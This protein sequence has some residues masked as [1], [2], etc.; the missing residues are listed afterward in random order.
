MFL[1][2][3][4][5][6]HSEKKNIILILKKKGDLEDPGKPYVIKKEGIL[7]QIN[8]KWEHNR[9]LCD[10][11]LYQVLFKETQ[12]GKWKV[13]TPDSPCR[14]Q[15]LVVDGLKAD[16]SYVFKVRVTEEN[17]GYDG[18]FSPESNIIKT[19]ETPA[20]RIRKKS[21]KVATGPPDVYMLPI[22]ENT[23]ARNETAQTRKFTLGK[24]IENRKI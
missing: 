18:P 14:T 8:L 23:A 24:C 19:D 12:D 6:K 16:T 11:E 4:C 1:K 7:D 9:D 20:I 21:Q 10:T 5:F 13:F 15:M 2:Y 22:K 3:A 17:T